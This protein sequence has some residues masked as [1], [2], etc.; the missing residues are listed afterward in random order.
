MSDTESEESIWEE[1]EIQMN[2]VLQCNEEALS[3]LHRIQNSL[4]SIIYFIEQGRTRTFDE[5]LEE[6]AG[7]SPFLPRLLDQLHQGELS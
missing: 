7:S 5:V 4:S 1:V 3:S 6:L 2:T